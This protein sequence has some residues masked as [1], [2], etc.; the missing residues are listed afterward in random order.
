MNEDRIEPSA[1][2]LPHL[3]NSIALLGLF[4]FT[5]WAYPR[6]PGKIPVHFNAAGNPDC[7]A[8]K[9][10]G[11]WLAL[12]LVALGLTMFMYLVRWSMQGIRRNARWV[13][14]PHKAQFLALPPGRQV[15]IW[16]R[17]RMMF[18]W[19][20]VPLNGLFIFLQ[21]AIWKTAL[22]QGMPAAFPLATIL[23]VV[24]ELGMVL[25]LTVRLSRSIRLAIEEHEREGR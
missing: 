11:I 8:E 17:L 7:W 10:W 22:G 21:V 19:L 20:A 6:L 2:R 18:F 12:P 1:A 14:I 23:F 9:S 24:L 16:Q 3:L 4:G 25:F 5:G 15:P 13:N